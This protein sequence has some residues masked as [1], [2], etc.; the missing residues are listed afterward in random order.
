MERDLV[1]PTMERYLAVAPD[2]MLDWL[3]V[4]CPNPDELNGGQRHCLAR[5][6]SWS[7]QHPWELKKAKHRRAQRNAVRPLCFA[8]RPV[9][10]V[11]GT[12][13]TTARPADITSVR[14]SPSSPRS[15]KVARLASAKNVDSR[16]SRVTQSTPQ[17]RLESRTVA[18]EHSSAFDRSI[19]ALNRFESIHP[20]Q[21]L[22][23]SLWKPCEER[24]WSQVRTSLE[25]CQLSV[26]EDS[27]VDVNLCIVN[28]PFDC[29]TYSQ[30]RAPLRRIYDECRGTVFEKST[31]RCVCLGLQKFWNHRERFA[32]DIDWSTAVAAEKVDGC[33]FKLFWYKGRWRVASNRHLD[34][35]SRSASGKYACTGRSN[36]ELFHEAAERSALDYK[37]LDRRY[38]YILERLHPEFVIVLV[39]ARPQLVHLATRNMHTLEEVENVD[40]GLP[41]PTEWRVTSLDAARKLLDGLPGQREGL[42]VRDAAFRRIKLKRA[43]Y[44]MMHLSANGTNSPDYS[45]CARS[46]VSAAARMPVDRLCLN[47]WLRNEASEFECYFPEHRARYRAIAAALNSPAF[48]AEG[49]VPRGANPRERS[50]ATFLHEERLWQAISLLV[51]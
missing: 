36:L 42:V 6:L 47:V 19:T 29:E 28:A 21:T 49:W 46:A 44:V 16:L 12:I 31:G 14:E 11:M 4:G 20:I 48:S 34:V 23:H 32:A 27:N 15:P 26:E 35:S 7:T 3:L 41:K 38:C 13:G 43:D 8:L 40:A 24:S 5:A 30:A 17:P 45:W 50:G 51:V 25:A 33:L 22:V 1:A 9:S 39:P 18:S 10:Q 2:T 37:R